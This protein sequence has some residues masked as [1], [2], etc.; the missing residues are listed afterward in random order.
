MRVCVRA[1]TRDL[2]RVPEGNL[3]REPIDIELRHTDSLA[4][5][6]FDAIWT[7]TERYVD[8]NRTFFEPKLRAL[9]EV[10]LWRERGGAL[11]GL[12]GLDVYPVG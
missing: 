1:A 6:E 10:G 8:T 12:V 3:P 5:E 7:V 9:P 11:V 2:R 4:P